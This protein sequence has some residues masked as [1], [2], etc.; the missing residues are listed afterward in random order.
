M[1]RLEEPRRE[2]RA[3]VDSVKVN[4]K[5]DRLPGR[6]WRKGRILTFGIVPENPLCEKIA[7]RLLCQMSRCDPMIPRPMIPTPIDVI[8]AY[9]RRA[10]EAAMQRMGF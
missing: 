2:G 3:A 4:P 9:I 10:P 6:K 7:M 1:I 8:G 5:G